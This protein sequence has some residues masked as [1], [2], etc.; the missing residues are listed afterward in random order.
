MIPTHD[1]GKTQRREIIVNRLKRLN[2]YDFNNP[3]RHNYFEFFYFLKGGGHHKIDFID[4]PIKEGSAHIVAPGQVHQMNRELD[5]EGFVILFELNAIEAPLAIQDFL[6]EH[7]CMDASEK[8]PSFFFSVSER[9]I[10]NTKIQS[11][12]ELFNSN[13]ALSKL[14]LRNEIHSFCIACMKK[15]KH[16]T[17]I[18]QSEYMQFRKLLHANFSEMKKVRE[19]AEALNLTEKSLSEMVKKHTGLST[20]NIIYKQLIME[21]KRLLNTQISIKETA[22]ALNFEDPA[23]FSKFFKTQTGF[24]PSEFQNF[25]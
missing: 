21:A 5:S 17:T 1:S 23:H 18:K 9:E 6:F 25:K 2:G 7:I 16:I 4:F 20:S 11:I 15:A 3:H 24:S 8:T 14:S 10:L 13:D 22:F 12:W 19:Y